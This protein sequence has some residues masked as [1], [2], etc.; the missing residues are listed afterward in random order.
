MRSYEPNEFLNNLRDRILLPAIACVHSDSH[1][2]DGG[3]LELSRTFHLA[4]VWL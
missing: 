4:Y 1:A 3:G 2:V